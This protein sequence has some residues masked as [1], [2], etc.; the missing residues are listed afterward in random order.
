MVVIINLLIAFISTLALLCSIF[1][2]GISYTALFISIITIIN[3]I[4]MINQNKENYRLSNSYYTFIFT[5]SNFIKNKDFDSLSAYLNQARK[6]D[7][8]KKLHIENSDMPIMET[9][10]QYHDDGN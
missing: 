8:Y 10:K 1:N 4:Q 5:I 3:S 9:L 2:G 6:T 7:F